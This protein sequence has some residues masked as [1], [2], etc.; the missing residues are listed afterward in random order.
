MSR[1]VIVA[2]TLP[3]ASLWVGRRT[4]FGPVGRAL[5]PRSTGQGQRFRALW[6]AVLP[7]GPLEAALAASWWIIEGVLWQLTTGRGPRVPGAGCP[8]G[9]PKYLVI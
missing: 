9:N 7:R 5:T 1:D 2:L 3:E 4:R 8:F 6:R